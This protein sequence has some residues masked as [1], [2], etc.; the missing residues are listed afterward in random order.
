[1]MSQTDHDR[2]GRRASVHF[3][4]F[5]LPATE[6]FLG[7]AAGRWFVDRAIDRFAKGVNRIHG[8][9][10]GLG[11]KEK[12]II[13]I[14]SALFREIGTKCLGF[15]TAHAHVSGHRR[16]R[17]SASLVSFR[18]CVIAWASCRSCTV[19]VFVTA[20]TFMPAAFAPRIPGSES[21]MTRH[22]AVVNP[23]SRC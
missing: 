14:T 5:C 6:F 12:G 13:K 9:A 19:C 10:P 2:P 11:K 4:E 23:A 22:D 20:R 8:I 1:M 7:I 3:L 21:S 17:R 15:C 16:M 18:L